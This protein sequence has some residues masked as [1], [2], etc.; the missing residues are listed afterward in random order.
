VAIGRFI[1][2]SVWPFVTD[3]VKKYTEAREAERKEFVDTLKTQS[4]QH[5]KFGEDIVE[6]LRQRDVELNHRIGE[7][8]LAVS[9][10]TKSVEKLEK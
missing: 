9:Q 7:F 3:Y 1:S 10:L 6:V 5:Q 8:T 4:A 2:S